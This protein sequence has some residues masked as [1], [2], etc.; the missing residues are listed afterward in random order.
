MPL[1]RKEQPKYLIIMGIDIRKCQYH[2]KNG[3]EWIL[4]EIHKL[5]K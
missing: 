4:G 2:V 5:V 1:S 3:R